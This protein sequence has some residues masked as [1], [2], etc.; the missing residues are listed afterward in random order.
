MSKVK[1]QPY[2]LFR[3]CPL[4]FSGSVGSW[5]AD[6]SGA[7]ASRC[8]SRAAERADPDDR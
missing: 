5:S 3:R 7:S 2:F 1:M 8:F 6:E 4:P